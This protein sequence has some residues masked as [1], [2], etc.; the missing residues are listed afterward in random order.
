MKKSD[1]MICSENI[2]HQHRA[3]IADISRNDD[4]DIST[5]ARK[6]ATMHDIPYSDGQLK[7]F[8]DQIAMLQHDTEKGANLVKEYFEGLDGK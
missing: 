7:E 1:L 5:A 8:E 4:C 2:F 3:E 6:Y